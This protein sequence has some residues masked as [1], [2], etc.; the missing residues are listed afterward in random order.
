MDRYG[1]V[2]F[3]KLTIAN[4]HVKQGIV[5]AVRELGG[6]F[7]EL[8]EKSGLYFDIGDKKALAKTSQALREGQTKIRKQMHREMA[9]KTGYDTSLLASPTK[10]EQRAIP[11]E[12]YFGYSI[13]VLESLYSGTFPPQE[14][15]RTVTQESGDSAEDAKNEASKNLDLLARVC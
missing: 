5:D 4:L 7:I 2:P 10:H 11:A 6:R 1:I 8:D 15:S 9:G 3:H 12:G 14:R 13:Q